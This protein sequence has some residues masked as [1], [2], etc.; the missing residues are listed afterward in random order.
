[1]S[2]LAAAILCGGRS[3][4]MGGGEKPLL[5]LA[6]QP[7]LAHVIDRLRGSAEALAINAN[8]D[9]AHYAAFGLPVI[10]DATQDYDGPLAGILAGLEWA[11]ASG[12][13]RLVTAAG[14]TPFFPADL[15]ARLRAAADEATIAVAASESGVHP[16]FAVW[17][18]K[19]RAE[20][21]R[22]LAAGTRKVTAFIAQHPSVAVHFEPIRLE[23]REFDP[24][25]NINTP[26]D[27]AQARRLAAKLAP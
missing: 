3:S 13:S 6:G 2:G 10:A 17:P 19:L 11:H 23:G 7:I 22:Q 21:K 18:V 1:M 8:G 24:F 9:P 14:D 12:A 4:R 26:D 25:F 20:L 16:T 5:E 15:V 27:L